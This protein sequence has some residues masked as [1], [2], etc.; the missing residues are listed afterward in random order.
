MFNQVA[1]TNK[2]QASK[3][4][5]IVQ[6]F[7]QQEDRTI[8]ARE[9]KDPDRETPTIEEFVAMVKRM[10]CYDDGEAEQDA[11]PPEQ[12]ARKERVELS[13]RPSALL[14]RI[15]PFMLSKDLNNVSDLCLFG[16]CTKEQLESMY[17]EF[18]MVIEVLWY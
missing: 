18:E 1:P 17:A 5:E 2:D 16:G 15:Y 4:N 12:T 11:V 6:K 8:S 7:V 3:V 14:E 13:N 9:E 10:E